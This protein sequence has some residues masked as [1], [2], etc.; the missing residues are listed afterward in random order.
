MTMSTRPRRRRR[1]GLAAAELAVTLPF[2]VFTA[3]ATCDFARCMYVAETVQNCA[4]NGAMYA[5]YSTAPNL[6]P[7]D[8]YTNVTQAAAADASNLDSS[9]IT[10]SSTTGTD[11]NGNSYVQVTVSYP[12]TTIMSYPGIPSSMTISR[13]VK[14]AVT[15]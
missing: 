14:M 12:F 3:V 11:A 13:T 2:L 6:G 15:P 4:R 9:K 10:S 7:D 1:R 5:A 8:L